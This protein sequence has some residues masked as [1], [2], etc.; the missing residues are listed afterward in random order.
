MATKPVSPPRGPTDEEL[1]TVGEVTPE[2]API[3]TLPLTEEE[4]QALSNPEP[5][6]IDGATVSAKLAA[7][8]RGG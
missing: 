7:R 6:W 3:D 1:L 5:K 8:L 2:N 4:R